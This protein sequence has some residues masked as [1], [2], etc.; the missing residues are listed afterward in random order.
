MLACITLWVQPYV[1]APNVS[2]WHVSL[3]EYSHINGLPMFHADMYHCKYSHIY[4]LLMFY[5]GMYHS[6]STAIYMG[7]PCFMLTCITLWVQPYLWAPSVSCCHVSAPTGWPQL[8]VLVQFVLSSTRSLLCLHKLS[9]YMSKVTPTWLYTSDKRPT[10]HT[11]FTFM[12][13]IHCNQ[14]MH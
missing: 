10:W 4:G 5:A 6:V 7:S 13:S 11:E 14:G 2:C 9:S 3:C 12:M 8:H 1:W